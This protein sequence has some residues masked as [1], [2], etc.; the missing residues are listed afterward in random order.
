MSLNKICPVCD[1]EYLPEVQMC[2]DCE[3]ALGWAKP[4][5][6]PT[7]PDPTI[8]EQ[9]AP[10]EVLG[11]VARDGHEI[12][13]AYLGH[14]KAAGITAGVLPMTRYQRAGEFDHDLHSIFGIWFTKG[15]SGQVPLYD[16]LNGV[17]QILFVGEAD[18]ERARGII[19][20]NFAELHPDNP[21]GYY[22][23]FDADSCPACGSGVLAEWEACP[24]CGL[25]F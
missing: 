14:F 7:K 23:E 20:E 11:Q 6:D 8:W 13:E 18:F 15:S 22:N 24:D 2:A 21:E 4:A 1:S 10:G 16:G 5:V 25:S 9:L 19:E 17:P 12:I 3:V